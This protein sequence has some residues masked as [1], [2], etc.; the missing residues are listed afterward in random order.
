MGR[1]SPWRSGLGF[2]AEAYFITALVGFGKFTDPLSCHPCLYD[3]LI[4]SLRAIRRTYFSNGG[5]GREVMSFQGRTASPSVAMKYPL[6]RGV[7]LRNGVAL[8]F[9][10]KIF[11][12]FYETVDDESYDCENDCDTDKKYSI[13]RKNKHSFFPFGFDVIC[14][15]FLRKKA[16]TAK[17]YQQRRPVSRS[18][19]RKF[20]GGFRVSWDSTGIVTFY[21]LEKLI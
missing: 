5:L 14:S 9:G 2:R 13:R 21:R 7:D 15:V 17:M 6:G 8:F 1:R 4:Q 11:E 19:G 16:P 18:F 10:E 12:A 3:E 20:L